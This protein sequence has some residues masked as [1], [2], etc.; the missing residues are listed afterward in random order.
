MKTIF[1]LFICFICTVTAIAF[2]SCA[3]SNTESSVAPAFPAVVTATVEAGSV[4][5]LDFEAN[6]PWVISIPTST[7]TYFQ[8]LDGESHVYTLRGAEGKHQVKI[9]VGNIEDYDA[10][11][12]CE[13]TMEMGGMREVIATLTLARLQRELAVYPAKLEEGT[14]TYTDEGDIAYEETTISEEGLTMIWPTELSG[15]SARIKVVSN[16]NWVVDGAPAWIEPI[17]EG[18]AGATEVWLKGDATK[19][20]MESQSA[21]IKFVDATKTDIV[22]AEV[23]LTIPSATS[24]FT[25]DGFSSV[26]TFNSDAMLY[27]ASIDEYVE[28]EE[29]YTLGS[30]V[31]VKGAVVLV[32]ECVSTAMGITPELQPKWIKESISAWDS[33]DE[34]VIQRR[35]INVTLTQNE[36]A[37]R[38][39][40]LFVVPAEIANVDADALF[41]IVGNTVLINEEYEQY[42]ATII[43]QESVPGNIDIVDEEN[44]AYMG[45]KIT[46]LETGHWLYGAFAGASEGYEL[47]HTNVLSGEEWALE[48]LCPYTSI[49]CYSATDEGLVALS[50]EEAWISTTTLEEGNRFRVT[51]DITKP[52][53]ATSFN[54]ASGEHEGAIAI[55]NNDSVVAVFFCRYNE[56]I[57]IGGEVN[58]VFAYPGYAASWDH[59]EL[60][61]ITDGQFYEQYAK[62]NVPIYHLLYTETNPTMS[63][64][65]GLTMNY[66]YENEED[67]EWLTYEYSEENQVIVMNPDKGDG[68]TGALFFK[69]GINNLRLILICTLT[70]E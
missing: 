31:A 4:Y 16:V 1:K 46:P 53:A 2:T 6:L 49:V 12:I 50:G 62:Y 28:S 10:D 63:M 60:E 8:I 47:L 33:T 70:L 22:L 39:A 59:S 57:V 9:N 25:L 30:V 68:K 45:A 37:T 23:N 3:D 29:G 13:V 35:S 21:T 66:V 7:A 44:M 54:E 55:M 14:Y 64:L 11:H 65:N 58:V 69:D 43:E 34:E 61:L 20:P 38:Q 27:S 56:N 42:L 41:D 40:F 26:T 32:A 24:I 5:T 36:G 17:S 15:F 51:M 19:Y 48:I 18:E 67:K 52:T